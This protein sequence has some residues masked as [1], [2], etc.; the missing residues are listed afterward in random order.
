MNVNTGN[1]NQ[2]INCDLH[3]LIAAVYTEANLHLCGSM[4]VWQIP[5]GFQPSP[6][7]SVSESVNSERRQLKHSH[8]K[9]TG[10]KQSHSFKLLCYSELQK[11]SPKNSLHP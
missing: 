5:S 2:Q 10:T 9:G 4:Y 7:E 6:S 8:A 11:S 1:C 3:C